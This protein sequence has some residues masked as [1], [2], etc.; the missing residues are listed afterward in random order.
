MVKAGTTRSRAG[1]DG[2][3]GIRAPGAGVAGTVRGKAGWRLVRS[4][5]GWSDPLHSSPPWIRAL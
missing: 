4:T 5:S 3:E 2:A 1:K